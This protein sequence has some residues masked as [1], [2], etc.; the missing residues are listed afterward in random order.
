MGLKKPAVGG[1]R[2]AEGEGIAVINTLEVRSLSFKPSVIIVEHFRIVGGDKQEVI[3]QLYLTPQS[4]LK[5]FELGYEK[6]NKV[7]TKTTSEG[8]VETYGMR[9]FTIYDN[10]FSVASVSPNIKHKWYA[11]E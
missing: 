8:Y 6:A 5:G 4:A 11:F 10:G 9:E 1:K 3:R 7:S 2:S